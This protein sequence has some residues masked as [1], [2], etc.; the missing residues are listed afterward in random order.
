[1][2]NLFSRNKPQEEKAAPPMGGTSF[3]LG[4]GVSGVN[5]K[6]ARDYA[7]EGYS[8]NP[9]VYAC[10][11]KIATALG[12]AEIELYKKVGEKR[13]EVKEH[14]LLDLLKRPNPYQSWSV[15]AESAAAWYKI[16]GDVYILRLPYR[17]GGSTTLPNELWLLDPSTMTPKYSGGS[18]VG[19]EQDLGGKKE[20]FP[21]D[22]LTGQCDV[23]HIKDFNPLNPAVGMTGIASAAAAV[24][25]HNAAQLWNKRLLDNNACPSGALKTKE[26]EAL[27][28]QQYTRLR[29]EI[30]RKYSGPN[31]AGRPMLLEGG[32]SWEEMGMTPRDMHFHESMLLSSRMIAGALGV[33]PQ[34]VNIPGESTYSNYAEAKMALWTE[35]VIPLLKLFIDELNNWLVPMF[36]DDLYLEHDADSIPALQPLRQIMFN[37]A[38]AA[39]FLTVNEKR[40]MAG[41]EDV[42]GGDFVLVPTGQIP[43][44]IL[45]VDG[46][47][48]N[49][50][51]DA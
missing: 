46:E 48:G 6:S 18:V 21:V 37:N 3:F 45:D 12:T 36:G 33:P 20:Y 27:S 47:A 44:D 7:D 51:S 34:L 9:I 2:F 4:M 31:G 17:M 42:E 8:R 16:A 24:D 35:T 39:S 19:Y 43:L 5:A 28:D 11:K 25:S 29:E 10:V 32:L 50:A 22:A 41:F 13:E 23:L 26:G 30:D 40:G 49:D 15:F 1:M 38:Q 14:E